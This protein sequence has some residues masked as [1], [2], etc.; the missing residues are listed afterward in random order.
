MRS[1]F[2]ITSALLAFL[3]CD[4]RG[5]FKHPGADQPARRHFHIIASSN[6]ENFE[7]IAPETRVALHWDSRALS[8]ETLKSLAG[9]D[10]NALFLLVYDHFAEMPPGVLYH[11]Y[12]DLPSNAKPGKDDIHYV[13]SLNFYGRISVAGGG[14]S[15]VSY[16][17]TALIKS[18]AESS[19]LTPMTTLSILPSGSPLPS[20]TPRI[21]RIELVTE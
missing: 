10:S 8:A 9:S 4:A 1:L 13:G 7:L 17:V 2:I 14:N 5:D 21:G 19:M 18:L 11:L 16:D 3:L 6:K 12:F 20:A 15:F